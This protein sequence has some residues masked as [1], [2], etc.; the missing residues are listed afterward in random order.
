M[1]FGRRADRDFQAEIESHLRLEADRLMA[2]GMPPAD[3]EA[4]ARRAFGNVT[5]VR[6]GFYELRRRLWWE[7]L[8]R[9]LRYGMRSLRKTPVF[10]AAVALT[11]AFGVGANTGVFSLMDAVLLRS[12]PVRHP[13]ELFFLEAAGGDGRTLVPP[14]PCFA[15]LR[16]QARS[17]A[18]MAAFAS[19]E[20]QIEIDGKPEQVVGQVASGN[21]FELLGVKPALGRLMATEDEELNPPV[22]VISDRY[23]RRRF[24]G[25]PAAIGKTIS[26]RDRAF[27]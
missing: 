13:G 17:F 25:D 18:G 24:G 5:R 12:L 6:E 20:L 22:A 21:Y 7:Q 11:I 15:R 9:D 14:Y 10:T 27:T 2:E 1:W 4:A 3:A 16:A 8:G 19:D 23:W 26:F